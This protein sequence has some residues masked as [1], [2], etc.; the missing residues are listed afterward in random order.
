MPL[1]KAVKHKLEQLLQE[2]ETD[3][4]ILTLHYRNDGDLNFFPEADRK[5]VKKI[6]DVLIQDTQRHSKII[7]SIIEL[8]I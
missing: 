7:Q 5:Q 3:L 8:E 6:L 1:A 4:Y 2:E